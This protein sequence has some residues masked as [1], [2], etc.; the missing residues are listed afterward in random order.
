MTSGLNA[1][2]P[3]V[4][5]TLYSVLLINVPDN[6]YVI[7]SLCA[8][9]YTFPLPCKTMALLLFELLIAV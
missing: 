8:D 2:P 1:L 5:M 6:I 7:L 9:Y 4:E 3:R